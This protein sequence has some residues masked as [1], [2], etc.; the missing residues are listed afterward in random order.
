MGWFELRGVVSGAQPAAGAA[1]SDATDVLV[2]Q[3][4]LATW[5]GP[6]FYG[7][8]TACGRR[9]TRNLL[10]VANRRLRCGTKVRVSYRGRSLVVPVVDRGPFAHHAQWDLTAATARR[11]GMRQTSTIGTAPLALPLQPPA[12]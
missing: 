9:L 11:L 6:G 8:R 5:Y 12:L 1:S 2:Y 4:G 7:R 10:G 3:P